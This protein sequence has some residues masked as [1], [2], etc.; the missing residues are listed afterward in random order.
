MD[1][2]EGPRYGWTADGKAITFDGDYGRDGVIQVTDTVCCGCNRA[3]MCLHADQSDGEYHPA[4][5]CEDCIAKLFAAM[6]A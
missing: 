4:T 5:V 6:R 3:A 2:D 1:G